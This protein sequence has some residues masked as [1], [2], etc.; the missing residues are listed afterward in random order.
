M[1]N[2][3]FAELKQKHYTTFSF[4]VH[5]QMGHSN[6]NFSNQFFLS[7]FY[8]IKETKHHCIQ[9]MYVTLS[10]T[11]AH[12]VGGLKHFITENCEQSPQ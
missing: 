9:N 4:F 6:G 2:V 3:I 11:H 10:S 8:T 12:S 7:K 5:T 1:T